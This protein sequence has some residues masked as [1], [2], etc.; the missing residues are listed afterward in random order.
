MMLEV[1]IRD[2]KFDMV[3]FRKEYK[4]EL[5]VCGRICTVSYLETFEVLY[6]IY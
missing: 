5:N 4:S 2:W 1:C 6:W 3:N